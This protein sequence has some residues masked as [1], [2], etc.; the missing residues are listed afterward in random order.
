MTWEWRYV[1]SKAWSPFSGTISPEHRKLSKLEIADAI[2]SGI[3]FINA[4]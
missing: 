3:R 4:R 2:L 1:N